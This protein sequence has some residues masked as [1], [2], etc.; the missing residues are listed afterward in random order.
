MIG[1]PGDTMEKA[2]YTAKRIVE[3]GANNTRIYPALV[4]KGTEFENMY[5]AGI[6][7]PL[8]LDIAVCWSKEL[9]KIFESG[10]V[11]VI[12][13][14]L[15]PSEGLLSGH[16]LIAGPF[17]QSFRELVL[18]EIWREL[19]KP[20]LHKRGQKLEISVPH[21][22]FNYAVGY[23]AGNKKLLLKNFHTVIFKPTYNL[24]GREFKVV[25][26]GNE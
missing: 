22:Q 8:S 19:F 13:L 23:G 17:H 10:G 9:L 6:Y 16:D 20:L 3:L 25:V 26:S 2:Q 11:D 24:K 4:I 7:K 15:H 14:G 12:K 1:L 18:T 21:G 5:S